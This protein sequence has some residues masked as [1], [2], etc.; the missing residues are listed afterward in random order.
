MQ[1]RSIGFFV[2]GGTIVAAAFFA[3]AI[4]LDNDLGWGRG[5]I[6]ILVFGILTIAFGLFYS[7]YTD[8]VLS[9]SHTLQSSISQKLTT[10]FGF[11]RR[12]WYIFPVLILVILVY[13]WF[14]SSG[15]WTR[16]EPATR[17]YAELANS[18]KQGQ[19][20]LLDEPNEK[21]LSLSNPYDPNARQGVNYFIDYSLYQGKYYLYWGPVPA[22]LLIVIDPFTRG[23]VADL[24]LVFYF[25][26]GIFLFQSLFI[27]MM[28]D[29]FFRDLPKWILPLS[30]FV[31]GLITPWTYMLINEPNGRI[32]EASISVAQ[33]F[34]V[35]GGLV[36]VVALDRP[37]PS[38][39]LLALTGFLWAL[40]IGTRLVIALPVG[41]LSIM[42]AYRLWK[43]MH[44]SPLS[45]AGKM[46][47]L[48]LPLILCLIGSGWYN[49]ARFGSPTETG[50]AYQLAGVNQNYGNTLFSPT[51]FVQNLYTYVFH[52]PSV[53]PQFPFLYPNEIAGVGLLFIAPFTMFA[54]LSA[55]PLLR[56]MPP[57]LS[58]SP[59]AHRADL[60]DWI[61]TAL[62]GS[63][64][65]AFGLLLISLWTMIR[66]LADFMPAL[67]IL[68]ILGF[69]QGYQFLNQSPRYQRIYSTLGIILAGASITV[70][71][72]LSISVRYLG[73]TGF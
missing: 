49:W 73:R 17:Y 10:L 29:R 12:D 63:F 51:Y 35:S 70:N 38:S 58:S 13:V 22:L 34:L 40:A 64:L 2:L 19:L 41:F 6:A 28:R 3:E 43:S 7:L 66:Y 31:L 25:V 47:S 55:T 32:Y 11:L 4:G 27:V 50:I 23:R 59:K 44:L 42:I 30:I 46:F 61:V 33:F 57:K 1:T 18:F 60:L 36:A 65:S 5:R 21:L 62:L 16:W 20:H 68:S 26:C 14:A 8:I 48:S 56:K 67:T 54:I 71:I 37:A 9:I 24:Y 72:L 15:S 39:L 53:V 52:P 45:L 69:W